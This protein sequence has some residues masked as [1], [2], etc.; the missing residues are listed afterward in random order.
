VDLPTGGA[1][2]ALV[3]RLVLQP[4][5]GFRSKKDTDEDVEDAPRPV[6][7]YVSAADGRVTPLRAEIPIAFF[8]AVIRLVADCGRAPCALPR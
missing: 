2:D 7:L 1:V 4:I 3:I 5:A 8:T 6:T